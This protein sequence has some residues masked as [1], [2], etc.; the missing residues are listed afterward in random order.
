MKNKNLYENQPNK[1]QKLLSLWILN[2]LIKMTAHHWS[3]H[4]MDTSGASFW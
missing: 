1:S 2:S 4:F 3:D